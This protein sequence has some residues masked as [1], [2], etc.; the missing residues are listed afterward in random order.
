[1]R[2]VAPRGEAD[3]LVRFRRLLTA[4]IAAT[5]ALIVIGGV[6]RVSDSGLGCGAAGSGTQGWPLCGGRLLPFL[7]EHQV[8]EFSHRLVATVVVVLI[9]ALAVLAFRR[10]RDHR[11]LVRG[12]IAAGILVLAQAA[13]GGLTVEHGLHTA[14]VAAHLGLAML[15]LGLLIALRRF[16]QPADRL[17]PIDGSRAL[18][19]TAAATAVL[20]FATI[21]AGGYVAGTEGEGTPDK[22]VL[23]AHLACGEQFPTCLDKFMPFQYGRLVD[24]QLTHRLLMYLTTIA[25]IAMTAVA[26]RRR[27]PSRA[28]AAVPV[29]LAGQIL[30]G[31]MNVWLGKHPWLVVAHLTLATILWATVV[32]AA[33]LLL[34]VPAGARRRLQDS[35][36]TDTQAVAA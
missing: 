13:L 32:F 1:M 9:V 12:T 35:G 18:R 33:V 20:L 15:L 3:E 22:P 10:L 14:L 8:I 21:V 27:F 19:A 30:L 4:T 31:A 28:F 25:A 29:L 7:Q 6:V 34:E 16:A 11:L 24:I 2:R 23:G 26:W 17:D 36:A 5:F